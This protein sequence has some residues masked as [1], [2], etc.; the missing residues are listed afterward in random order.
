MADERQ[1]GLNNEDYNE[2]SG[3]HSI[4]TYLGDVSKLQEGTYKWNGSS[5]VCTTCK[6]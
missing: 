1:E 3:A 5:W 6:K 4:M 2:K